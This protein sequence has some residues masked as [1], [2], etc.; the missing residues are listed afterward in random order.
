MLPV[1]NDKR[2][3]VT[4]CILVFNAL[5]Y[6]AQVLSKGVVTVLGCKVRTL[7]DTSWLHTAP[8]VRASCIHPPPDQFG[9]CCWSV[10]APRHAR[11]AAR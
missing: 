10:V 3:R 1:F 2:R 11:C 7:S 9:H 6:L 5:M 4:D 8:T